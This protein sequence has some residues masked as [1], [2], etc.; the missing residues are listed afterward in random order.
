[1]QWSHCILPSFNMQGKAERR[2]DFI[3]KQD[4]TPLEGTYEVHQSPWKSGLK[5]WLGKTRRLLYRVMVKTGPKTPKGN[6]GAWGFTHC[7]KRPSCRS[8]AAG[9]KSNECRLRGWEPDSW[10]G[11]WKAWKWRKERDIQ[12]VEASV[13][14]EEAIAGEDGEM[15]FQLGAAHWPTLQGRKWHKTAFYGS[16][17]YTLLPSSG[18]LCGQAVSL[19]NNTKQ[20]KQHYPSTLKAIWGTKR[21]TKCTDWK[22]RCHRT[23]IW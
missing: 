2:N 17:F 23:V 16:D 4:Q 22:W 8:T 9:R 6:R 5:K 7:G 19:H 18:G 11:K 3:F 14:T 12:R 10:K 15:L 21:Q 13:L 1:M 20:W